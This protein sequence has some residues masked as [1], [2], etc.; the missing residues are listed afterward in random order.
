MQR[1]LCATCLSSASHNIATQSAQ[2]CSKEGGN[3]KDGGKE[4]FRTMQDNVPPWKKGSFGMT[5]GLSFS[6]KL[7]SDFISLSQFRQ[8]ANVAGLHLQTFTFSFHFG[9]INSNG[10]F[11]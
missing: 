8:K 6:C 9:Q 1:F 11:V 3:K 10:C 4:K 5:K 2:S 7:P